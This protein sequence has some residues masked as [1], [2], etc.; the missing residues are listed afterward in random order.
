MA[1]FF[2]FSLSRC[3]AEPLPLP[4]T[5]LTPTPPSGVYLFLG[6]Y[7]D[8]VAGFSDM[9]R[10]TV[11][12]GGAA[13]N[14]AANRLVHVYASL[15]W[16]MHEESA[17]LR[18]ICVPKLKQMC[19][20]RKCALKLVVPRDEL[21]PAEA[22]TASGLKLVSKAVDACRPFFV[23]ALGDRTEHQLASTHG[24]TSRLRWLK[25]ILNHAAKS[26]AVTVLHV[27]VL[28]AFLVPHMQDAALTRQCLF[29]TRH[30]SLACR[31]DPLLSWGYR[32]RV[33]RPQS[34]GQVSDDGSSRG[35]GGSS[36]MSRLKVGFAVPCAGERRAG[37]PAVVAGCATCSRRR[38]CPG[39]A[40][41][42]PPPPPPAPSAAHVD[43]Q[44]PAGER[45]QA[46][47]GSR[48]Q[49]LAAVVAAVV[50]D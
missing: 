25:Q 32:Q 23:C 1:A 47:A 24:V 13:A 16:D 9:V 26:S 39:L 35:S 49:R 27:E 14:N 8:Q 50:A 46:Q 38:V 43:G 30:P 21:A 20:D 5:P 42:P 10:A 34:L 4:H 37:A 29:Y 11:D 18:A 22:A 41:H 7:D 28:A 36:A 2:F 17:A 19:D 45:A 40:A 31:T 15:Q 3:T 44:E 6:A 48:P 33:K 12:F